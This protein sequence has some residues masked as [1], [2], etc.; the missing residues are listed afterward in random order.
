MLIKIDKSIVE[1]A[2]LNDENALSVLQGLATAQFKGYH[3]VWAK[4]SVLLQITQL[5]KLSSIDRNTYSSIY[6]KYATS[7]STYNRIEF[8]AL[9]TFDETSS[10]KEDH[11][12]INPTEKMD[13]NF[14]HETNLLAENLN[15]AKF[16]GL[17]GNNALRKLQFGAEFQ[18]SFSEDMGGGD[19]TVKKYAD[20]SNKA[21]GFCL[22]ILDG[23][24]KYVGGNYGDTCNKVKREDKTNPFNCKWYAINKVREVEN[25]L[26]I[27]LFLKD[28]N[29]KNRTIVQ[30]SMAFEMSYFD[31]KE[32]LYFRRLW[33]ENE[34]N[35][36]NQI[37]SA[38]PAIIKSINLA[39]DLKTMAV[40][41][42]EYKS[43]VGNETVLGGFGSGLFDYVLNKKIDEL[44]HVE[45]SELSTQQIQ[46]WNIIGKYIIEWCCSVKVDKV[47]LTNF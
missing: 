39:N 43:V 31:L 29:Y 46:E 9:V 5:N 26:P 42:D 3:I 32:G 36:W 23:D 13:F 30:D 45:D 10:R 25:L 18:L 8:Y 2:Y 16:F 37:F 22:A 21:K 15:D 19:T 47:L 24:I 12:V 11:I 41:Y 17:I 6:R 33:E 44:Q 35:Y 27:N 1:H 40:N 7:A 34:R 28:N 38:Y 14:V 20:Y 4:R